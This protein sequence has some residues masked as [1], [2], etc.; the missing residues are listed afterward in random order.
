M[1]C[2]NMGSQPRPLPGVGSSK[3]L[4]HELL[5][6]QS[7]MDEFIDYN[8]WVA[9]GKEEVAGER[10]NWRVVVALNMWETSRVVVEMS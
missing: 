6:E 7:R 4:W 8:C 2:S 3:C 9:V 10:D 5:D 1:T